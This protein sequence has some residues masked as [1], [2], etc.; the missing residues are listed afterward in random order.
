MR[1]VSILTV[2]IAIFAVTG[3]GINGARRRAASDI[4]VSKKDYKDCIRQNPGNPSEC[5]TLRLLYEADLEAVQAIFP[6]SI[7]AKDK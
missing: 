3:C 7:A 6:P 5:E 4:E 2:L 1:A